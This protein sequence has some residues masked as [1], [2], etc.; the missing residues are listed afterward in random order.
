MIAPFNKS[1]LLNPFET[2]RISDLGDA[3][4]REP[5]ALEPALK[6]VHEF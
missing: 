6:E 5:F 1:L 3:W 4:V 2:H